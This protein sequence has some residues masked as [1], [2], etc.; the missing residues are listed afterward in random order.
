MNTISKSKKIVLTILFSIMF[1]CL[2]LG[3]LFGFG[4]TRAA[5]KTAEEMRQIFLD[6]LSDNGVD[7]TNAELVKKI[8]NN[9][10][11]VCKMANGKTFVRNFI[12]EHIT[13]DGSG[14]VTS[15]DGYFPQ[16]YINNG[17]SKDVLS[18]EGYE[19]L[20]VVFDLDEENILNNGISLLS[21]NNEKQTGKFKAYQDGMVKA[22]GESVNAE[23][24][25]FSL[26]VM[27]DQQTAVEYH[28]SYVASS[29]NWIRDNA[30]AMNL[31]AFISVGDIVDDTEF[32]SWRQPTGNPF[33]Y[34]NYNGGRMPNYK[35]Q[36]NFA[37]TQA[38][39]LTA[40]NIPVVMTMGNHDYGDMAES[41]RVKD[42]FNQY[43]TAEKY[44][45][46][47]NGFVSSLYGDV[48]A[49]AYEFN[50]NGQDYLIV[51]LGCYPTDEM[52][53]WA[54]NVV[55]QHP[56]HKVI[57]STH[58]YIFGYQT[59][60]SIKMDINDYNEDGAHTWDNFVS[61]HENIFMVVCG[62]ECTVGGDVVKR[63]NYGVNG[64]AVTQ[65][66]INPQVE[67]FGGSGIITQM[68]FRKDGTVDFV[69]F[70][71]HV[72]NLS[73]KGYFL[74]ENQFSFTLAPQSVN[75]TG[76]AEVLDNEIYY[77]DVSE[78]SFLDDE[79][80]TAWRQNVYSYYNVRPTCRGLVT[81][82]EGYVVLKFNAGEGYSFNQ[83]SSKV[84][85]NFTSDN[86]ACM[87]DIST[88]GENWKNIL[89]NNAETGLMNWSFN[90]DRFVSGVE[91][92]YVKISIRGVELSKYVMPLNRVKTVH[93]LESNTL[94][95]NFANSVPSYNFTEWDMNG[96]IY[97]YFVVNSNGMLGSG[98][99]G[100]LTY[101]ST[102]LYKF[103]SG[104]KDRFVNG[105][106][107]DMNMFV[108]NPERDAEGHEIYEEDTK[109]FVRFSISLDNGET[110][111]R[112]KT[113][114]FTE[115]TYSNNIARPNI[116]EDFTQ[117]LGAQ[118]STVLL[119]VEYFGAGYTFCNTGIQ[120][121]A[122]NVNYN[123]A[124]QTPEIT[125]DLNGGYYCD[126]ILVPAKDGYKFEGWHLNDE[127]GIKVNPVDYE[128][129]CVTLCAKYVK[130]NSVT[131]MLYGATN[132]ADNET[133]IADG[134]TLV[135]SAPVKAGYKF[136]GWLNGDK[137]LVTSIT[138]NGEDIILYA[139]FIEE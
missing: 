32:L 65:F 78:Y 110:Y 5:S 60:N 94:S 132:S 85:G 53:T 69:Y 14:N 121:I 66:M 68:I 25:D 31:K 89:Y 36:L 59:V 79:N 7:T 130:L 139:F 52:L 39:K 118:A 98:G 67:E 51:S 34:V 95:Y 135:L 1:V 127:Q 107:L 61:L 123:K 106:S 109:Y 73:G 134:E 47:E 82:S 28:S 88:D 129:T 21:D 76:E 48:E 37:D 84:C 64:N 133:V 30:D 49:A 56:N 137:Q 6:Y 19:Y 97:K 71:P 50:A 77:S 10:P 112:V 108:I 92:L 9:D 93:D 81:D 99:S 27:G 18:D 126:D 23:D 115:L 35:Y 136:I 57:V 15:D 63:V 96:A 117:Y 125:F 43:F 101:K 45:R 54:N 74:N 120:D 91:T 104:M 128:G 72:E 122:F 70:S 55:S 41:Y 138:G 29:Y 13:Q 75:V 44:N 22:G 8:G 111:N 114:L 20:K 24:G 16:L 58:S 42:R 2:S 105:L 12:S 90:I 46:P 103:D 17:K 4:L 11:S 124:Y 83:A 86:G 131:Y 33:F 102:I 116:V 80:A 3:F 38:Q 26:I 113:H 62:H 87:V 40:L 100:K 119:K